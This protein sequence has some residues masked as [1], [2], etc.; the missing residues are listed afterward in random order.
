[1]AVSHPVLVLNCVHAE[2]GSGYRL[3]IVATDHGMSDMPLNLDSG[4]GWTQPT[5]NA[6]VKDDNTVRVWD[7]HTGKSMMEPLRGHEHLVRSVAFSADGTRIVS[8]SDDNTIRVWDANTG[9]SERE[10]LRDH[11]GRVRS[12][13]FSAVAH[14][15][16]RVPMT[17]PFAA[18]PR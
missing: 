4:G 15:L 2:Q 18:T 11:E 3:E 5:A 6:Q 16:C 1:M 12:V 7:A 9:K 8:G 17:R 13:M 10:P 14:T